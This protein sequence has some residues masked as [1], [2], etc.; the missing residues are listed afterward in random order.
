[1]G[2][3][4]GIFGGPLDELIVYEAGSQ[5]RIRFVQGIVDEDHPVLGPPAAHWAGTFPDWT[6]NF[7]DGADLGGAGEP[8]FIDVVLGVHAT[9]V[10]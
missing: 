4:L 7:E 3:E 2:E 5:V 6:I 9:V 10:P 1:V 8:D